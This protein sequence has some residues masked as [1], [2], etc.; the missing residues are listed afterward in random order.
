MTKT[1]T[2]NQLVK[3]GACS[4]GL[5]DFEKIF[6][7]GE[8]E[9]TVENCL[10]VPFADIDWLGDTLFGNEYMETKQPFYAEYSKATQPIYA[11]YKNARRALWGEYMETKQ[12]FYAEYEKAKE[13][14]WDEYYSA[15]RP[16]WDEY[17]RNVCEVICKLY[18]EGE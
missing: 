6:G 3:L 18:N 2:Y 16:F 4:S 7:R 14:L 12:P 15:Y 9:V 8:V 11:E 10:K 1:I 17:E 5:D 13:V